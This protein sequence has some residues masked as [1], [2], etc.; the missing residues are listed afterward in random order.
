[1]SNCTDEITGK[2]NNSDGGRLHLVLFGLCVCP[3]VTVRQLLFWVVDVGIAVHVDSDWI[4]Y[5]LR[6][7]TTI[8]Y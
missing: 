1:M 6:L 2:P 7:G 3:S 4:V 8:F 5:R